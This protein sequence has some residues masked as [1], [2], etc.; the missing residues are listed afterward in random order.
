MP[1]VA[2]AIGFGIAAVST[3]SA[4]AATAVVMEVGAGILIGAAIGAAGAALTG[5]DI[6]QGA[7]LGGIVGGV[8]SGLSVAFNGVSAA[9]AASANEAMGVAAGA[10]GAAVAGET[11]S[12]VGGA[13]GATEAA[14]EA[15][16]AGATQATGEAVTTAGA[17]VSAEAAAKLAAE[18]AA[19]TVAGET[20]KQSGSPGFFGFL[21][22]ENPTML[23][24]GKTQMLGEGVKGVASAALSPDPADSIQAQTEG[25]IAVQAANDKA[26]QITLGGVNDKLASATAE[27]TETPLW[28]KIAENPDWRQ[29]LLKKGA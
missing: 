14:G 27:F 18:K 22:K 26:Q 7:L 4:V 19:G 10:E 1:P 17:E 29:P 11:G 25:Q 9:S 3:V 21:S 8:T 23:D 2:A 20:A 16:T 5:G 6:L 12:L 28:R 13:A 24:Y 15:V